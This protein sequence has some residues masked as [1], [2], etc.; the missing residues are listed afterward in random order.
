MTKIFV[1]MVGLAWAAS[2]PAQTITSAVAGPKNH[3]TGTAPLTAAQIVTQG[4]SIQTNIRQVGTN[5]PAFTSG[6][7]AKLANGRV[8]LTATGVPGTLFSLDQ[9]E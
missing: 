2:A 1:T 4:K 6:G 5:P 9:H 7:L 3:L 8:S